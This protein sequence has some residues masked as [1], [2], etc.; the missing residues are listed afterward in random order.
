MSAFSFSRHFMLD[1]LKT[2]VWRGQ[3]LSPLGL[4]WHWFENRQ[5]VYEPVV[6]DEAEISLGTPAENGS[7]ETNFVINFKAQICLRFSSVKVRDPCHV[8]SQGPILPL[9]GVPVNVRSR[10]PQLW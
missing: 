9:P 3:Y 10:Y 7:S 4:A 5:F 8:G 1:S 2:F 6:L